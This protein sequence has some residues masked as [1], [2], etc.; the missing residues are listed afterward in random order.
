MGAQRQRRASD[1]PPGR[2]GV[3]SRGV[4]VASQSGGRSAE[5][6]VVTCNMG[7]ASGITD[8]SLE[9]GRGQDRKSGGVVTCGPAAEEGAAAAAVRGAAGPLR[10]RGAM[11]RP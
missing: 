9:K 1:P 3:A 5:R 11:R 7:V 8:L 10:S 6:G 4:G 2:V